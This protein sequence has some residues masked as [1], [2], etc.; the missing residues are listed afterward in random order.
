[1][2]LATSVGFLLFG[3]TE[4]MFFIAM[5]NAF[6]TLMISTCFAIVVARDHQPEPLARPDAQAVAA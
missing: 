6:Y 2:G 3:L 4:A 1:M 5:T